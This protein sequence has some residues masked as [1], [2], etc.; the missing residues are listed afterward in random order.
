M[1]AAPSSPLVL[2][3]PV[4]NG[5][6]F[7]AETLASLNANG[8]NVRW[9]LQDGAS[10]DGTVEIARQFARPGDTVVSEPDDGQTDALNRAFRQMGGDIIGFLNADDLLLPNTARTVLDFFAAHPEIDLVYGEIDWIDEHGV[11]TGH[12]SGRID[13]LAEVLDIYGVWWADRQWVQPEVFFRRSLWE[14]TGSFDVK[15]RLA[16]DYDF[17]VRCFR[18]GARVARI[19]GP[20]SRFRKHTAQKSTAAQEAADEIRA[21]VRQHLDSGAPLPTAQRRTLE[22]QLAYDLYQGSTTRPSFPAALLRHPT[23][24]RAPQVRARLQAACA[25][26]FTGATRRP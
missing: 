2:A 21:I 12:H 13:S 26:L 20:L 5:G 3:V 18:V 11:V 8:G 22:A 24:L 14:K 16:F 19:T 1:S 6:R 9:W 17:W 4:F 7:L 25:R 15:W 23:W 10:Q